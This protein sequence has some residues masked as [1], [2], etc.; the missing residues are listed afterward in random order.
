L[1]SDLPLSFP[2]TYIENISERITLYRELDSLRSEDELTAY[3]KRLIDRFGPLPQEAE[4]LMNVVRL[5]WLCCELGIEKVFLKQEHLT[6]YFVTSQAGYFQSDVFGK[7]VQYVY[8]RG[9]RCRFVDEKDRK[10][11]QPTGRRYAVVQQV[12][13]VSGAIRLLSKILPQ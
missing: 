10:T 12:R 4:E 13:T 5:R 11:G 3:Q 2:N 7:I 6:L 1:E 8:S 9:D